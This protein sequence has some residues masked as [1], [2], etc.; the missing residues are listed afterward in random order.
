VKGIDAFVV[1][2]AEEARQTAERPIHVIEG[3]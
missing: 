2:D 1:G 3:R